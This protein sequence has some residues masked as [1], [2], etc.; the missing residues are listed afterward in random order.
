MAKK[1]GF[2]SP[3]FS[4]NWRNYRIHKNYSTGFG[5]NSVIHVVAASEMGVA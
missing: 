4:P 2:I 1:E 5:R 3:L